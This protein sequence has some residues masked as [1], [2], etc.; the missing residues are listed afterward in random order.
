[1]S[2]S[3]RNWAAKTVCFSLIL[4]FLL[5][6]ASPTHAWWFLSSKEESSV[7]PQQTTGLTLSPLL[8][9][10]IPSFIL[11]PLQK[12]TTEAPPAAQNTQPA[13]LTVKPIDQ[14]QNPPPATNNP[15]F[16]EEMLSRVNAIRRQNQLGS[17]S[18]NQ[19]LSKSAQAY[20]QQMSS[21]KFFSHTS[22][23]GQTFK[24]RNEQAGYTNWRWMGEN[25]GQ[26][27]QSV[28]EVVAAWM[29]SESHRANILS[30]K[31][32]ELGVGFK[33]GSPNFWVQEFGV[34][35]GE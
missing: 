28:E 17:L 34:Q 11:E 20:A 15:K 33:A 10:F 14:P 21:Q 26:G 7:Q 32:K 1:M 35:F 23:D 30:D 27:Q 24:H 5:S 12:T 6:T 2:I 4:L 18:L 19:Q 25:I 22:P 3:I 29:N 16:A 31:A 13:Q 8:Q 9:S